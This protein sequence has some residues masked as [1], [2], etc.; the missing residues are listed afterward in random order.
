MVGLFILKPVFFA[1]TTGFTT[2][3]FITDSK[4]IMVM[5]MYKQIVRD[6]TGSIMG[7]CSGNLF[8]LIH[9]ILQFFT[10]LEKW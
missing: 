3:L 7:Y 2:A 6:V 1:S 10:T 9:P 4:V 8:Q 5:M